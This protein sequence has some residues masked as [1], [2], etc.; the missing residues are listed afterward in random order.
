MLEPTRNL[1]STN[2]TLKG[3]GPEYLSDLNHMNTLRELN[4]KLPVFLRAKW[5]KEAGKTFVSG[6]RPRFEDFIQGRI[7]TGAMDADA[8]V[9][10][11]TM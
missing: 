7:Q 5:T 10:N 11:L 6:S 4:R 1:D 8:P 3:M 9:R 2:R